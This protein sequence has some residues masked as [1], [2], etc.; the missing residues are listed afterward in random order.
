MIER[1]GKG[2]NYFGN[3]TR[4]EKK[5]KVNELTSCSNTIRTFRGFRGT[6]CGSKEEGTDD[7]SDH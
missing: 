2:N 4:C 1:K 5:K 7:N 3:S 6:K